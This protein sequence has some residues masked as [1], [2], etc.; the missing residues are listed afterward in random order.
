MYFSII[1]VFPDMIKQALQEGVVARAIQS[2]KIHVMCFNPRD[3]TEDT[4]RTIDDRPF[5]GGPGMLMMAEPLALA[6]E[7]AKSQTSGQA[8]VIYCSPQGR[9][10]DQAWVNASATGPIQHFILLCGRYEG[11]DE[12]LIDHYVDQEISIGDYVLSG[13]ELP[14][15]VILDALARQYPDVLGNQESKEHDSFQHGLLDCPHYTRPA[16][17][18]GHEVPAVLQSGH[19]EKIM[20]WRQEQSVLRTQQRR[21]DLLQDTDQGSK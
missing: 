5:G 13:G 16:L 2:Q 18:R 7:D 14:A 3:Y 15:L 6:I 20:K 4:H 17:W 12:R 11:I 9:P 1:T 10:L 21:P 19:H 8:T